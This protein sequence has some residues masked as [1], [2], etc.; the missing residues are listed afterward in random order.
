MTRAEEVK[1]DPT[2]ARHAY[3]VHSIP[4]YPIWMVYAMQSDEKD[5][6]EDFGADWTDAELASLLETAPGG[7]IDLPRFTSVGTHSVELVK[8]KFSSGEDT[9]SAMRMTA[10][11]VG[12]G[13]SRV[14]FHVA[15]YETAAAYTDFLSASRS[16]YRLFLK[17]K[18]APSDLVAAASQECDRCGSTGCAVQRCDACDFR[19]CR[20]CTLDGQQCPSCSV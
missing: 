20:D 9:Q 1:A 7:S 6:D 15:C 12:L 10:L 13:R 2:V 14:R 19:V 16:L 17:V 11:T 4:S 8:F 3:L 18:A 5:D